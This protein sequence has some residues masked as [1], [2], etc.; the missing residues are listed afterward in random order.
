M[1]DVYQDIR[2]YRD[3]EVHE[4]MLRMANHPWILNGISRMAFRRLPVCCRPLLQPLAKRKIRRRLGSIA[5]VEEFQRDIIVKEV[6]ERVKDRTITSLSSSGLEELDKDEAYIYISNHRDI[7]LDPAFLN[8]FLFEY[9]FCI[10]EIAFGDN[11]MV[12]EL[13]SDLIRVNRAF[14]VRRNLPLREQLKA[15]IK[16][17]AYIWETIQ[18]KRSIW[19]AQREGRAKDGDDR[20]NPAVIKMLYLSNRKS[21]LSFSEFIRRCK[22]VPV[23]ISYEFDPCDRMKA[24][25]LY[26]KQVKGGHTKGKFEDLASIYAGITGFKGRLHYSFNQPLTGEYNNEKEVA[27]AIDAVIH[28]SYKQWPTNYI[29]YDHFNNSKKYAHL[30]TD[31]EEEKLITRLR[32]LPPDVRRIAYGCYGKPVENSEEKG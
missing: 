26:R 12:D 14:I 11:L 6:L 28:H 10:T 19:I 29:G 20:T 22:I 30:Y 32:R 7:A 1:A 5:S 23:A 9:D 4:I 25:E 16:L 31:D 24:W 2:P 13:V 21:D 17:S 8:Y 18:N 3:E 15:S 27:D